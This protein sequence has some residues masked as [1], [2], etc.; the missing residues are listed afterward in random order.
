MTKNYSN[1]WINTDAAWMAARTGDAEYTI[2]LKDPKLR[3]W[4]LLL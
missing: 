4:I 1:E 3:D 2:A